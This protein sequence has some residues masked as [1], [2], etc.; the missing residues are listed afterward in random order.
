MATIYI[1]IIAM[2]NSWGAQ[3]AHVEKD[4]T[5]IIRTTIQNKQF[6]VD[7]PNT[8]GFFNRSDTSI[9][10]TVYSGHSLD[11]GI[12]TVNGKPTKYYEIDPS[13]TAPPRIIRV[14]ASV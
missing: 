7:V 2:G 1:D 10:G 11:L 5:V 9:N 12:V 14:P 13:I 8:D 3:D 4:D 6:K